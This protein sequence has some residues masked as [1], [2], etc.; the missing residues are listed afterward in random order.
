M[1]EFI[2]SLPNNPYFV[3]FL[4][5]LFGLVWFGMPKT[6]WWKNHMVGDFDKSV[7]HPLCFDCN[8]GND[9]CYNDFRCAALRDQM[10]VDI[11]GDPLLH[12]E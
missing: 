10:K 12:R 8:E 2:Q 11:N 7:H 5:G 9:A 6:N 4:I 3:L 1:Y